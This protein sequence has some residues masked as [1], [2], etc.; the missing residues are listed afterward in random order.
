ML[1]LEQKGINP[2][3]VVLCLGLLVY[4][5]A[6]PGVLPGAID[7]YIKAPLQRLRAQP[8]CSED[9]TV[10]KKVASGG[11]GTVYRAEMKDPRRPGETR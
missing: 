11:F 3:G 7:T 5:F 1:R 6:T 9:F 4:L 2:Q 10:G 8:Y